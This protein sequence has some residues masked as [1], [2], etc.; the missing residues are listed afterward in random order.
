[1]VHLTLLRYLRRVVFA[2]VILLALAA[3]GGPAI[4]LTGTVIDVYTGAPVPGASI[5]LGNTQLTADPNGKY[6]IPRWNVKDT[7]QI[8]ASGYE[9]AAIA[10]TG[11]PGVEKPTPPAVTLDA[12]I[13]PNT[14]SGVVLDDFTD[15]PLAGALVK[16]SDT[17]SATTGADGRYTLSGLPERFNL[18][19]TA[20]DYA[21][22]SQDLE[23]TTNFDTSLRP[24]VLAGQITDQLTKQPIAGVTIK[25][26][27]ASATTD[28]EGRYRLTDVPENAEVQMS[29]KGYAT[30]TKTLGSVTT[31]DTA[32]RPNVLQG[33]LVDGES[34]NPIKNAT[35]VVAP[36][37]GQPDVG[38]VRI[39]NSSD[40]T[41]TLEN[42]P[43]QGVIQVLAPGYRKATIEIKPGAIPSEIK[44]E[45][46]AAKGLYITVAIASDLERV[47]EYL[48]IIDR[49]ELNAIVID[50]KS[51]LRD[52][53]GLIY[54]DSQAPIV[55]ELGTARAIMPIREILAE[56]KKRGIYTIARVHIFSLDNVLADAKPEWAAKDRTTGEVFADYPTPTIR[57]AWLDPWNENVWDYNIALSVE[58]AQMGFDEIN[59]DYIRFPSLEF[60]PEDK[61]RLQ[62][63]KENSTPEERFANIG[64]VLER[65]QRAINGA[66]AF[67][68]VDVFGYTAW[69]PGDL[70]GQ[71]LS[72]MSKH[73][74]YIMP[75]VYPSHFVPGELGLDNPATHPYKMILESLKRG[76]EQVAGNRAQVRPWLQ[77]FTLTWVAPS[78][79]VEYGPEEVRAQI[80]AVDDYGGN[81]GWML[82]DSANNYTEAALRPEE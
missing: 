19:V 39:D 54:Y 49:T 25:A 67:L 42:L 78:L 77:D 79:I 53:L 46:F 11:Q 28:A 33:K 4:P 55:K 15:Q 71:D 74:D 18:S 43:E 12:Q 21:A 7:L 31:F 24:N 50:L 32:L 56:A 47:K 64:A 3:C 22:F 1:M 72:V 65:S 75:M 35:V 45:P 16:A 76:A 62:L 20:A 10:L 58:A 69:G 26:G 57:Y 17:I 44:L 81:T 5:Q 60:D 70:I 14:L 2:V 6:S 37:P 73:T 52:D 27:D 80:R 66:G 82:Y 63:S 38:F 13:R 30:I 68:S 8:S 51:D 34:G 48:D 23:R 59:Y 41:F 29:V 36:A 9:P 40:G 61:N